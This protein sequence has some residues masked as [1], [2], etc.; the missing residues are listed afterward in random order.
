MLKFLFAFIFGFS[1]IQVNAQS[2][3]LTGSVIDP[4]S[5]TWSYGTITAIF[6]PSPGVPGPYT[7][8]GGA[9]N[10]LPATVSLD[11]GGNFTLS[12]PSNTAIVPSGSTWLINV[13]P[14]AS[15]QC[16]VVNAPLTGGSVNISSLVT[17]SSA[18]P[19]GGISPTQISKVYNVAQAGTPPLNQGGMVYNTT[20][21]TMNVY[22][23]GG[24]TPFAVVGGLP[25]VTNPGGNQ[26]VTQPLNTIFNFITSG[27]G[28]LQHNGNAVLDTTTGLLT[29]TAE[30]YNPS[31]TQTITQP[32]GTSTNLNTFNTIYYSNNY[33]SLALA[34]AAACNGT[35]P[36][37]VI[38]PSGTF[39]QS[40][41]TTIP[42]FCT[43]SGQG[44][45][46]I[47][48]G[49]LAVTGNYVLLKDF[50]V[51]EGRVVTVD[52]IDIAGSHVIMNDMTVDNCGNNGILIANSHVNVQNSDIYN[53]GKTIAG[54]QGTA[55]IQISAATA[56]RD[57]VIINNTIHDNS[58]GIQ[59]ANTGVT[60]QDHSGI[61]FT[62]NR[63]YN[64]AND[65]ILATI[66]N[67]GGGNMTGIRAEN[68][69]IFCNGWP[70]SGAGFST[71]C[72]AGFLQSGAVSS[73][74]G[75]G[76]DIIQQNGLTIL[77]SII[78][79]NY[80]HDN[81]FEAVALSTVINPVVSTSGTAVTWV[82]GTHFNTQWVAGQYILIAGVSYQIASVSSN[83]AL[84]LSTSAGTQTNVGTSVPG[85]MG[86][87]VAN[88]Y[89]LQNGGPCGGGGCTSVGPGFYN[90]LSDGNTY[91]N[92][93]AENAWLDGYI[94]FYS[95][96]TLYTGDSAFSN[97]VGAVSGNQAGFNNSGGF[98]VFYDGVSVGA[99]ST[100]SAV[101]IFNA[102][103]QKTKILANSI[104]ATTPITDT[105]TGTLY[106]ST[107]AT[108]TY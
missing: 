41:F 6:Q 31:S 14:N 58:G 56:I 22:G 71:N 69:E 60:G 21:Q 52:C 59:I 23:T 10:Q 27:T 86:A 90:E 35:V 61:S 89:S 12:L 36:G 5:Y 45:Q 50:A 108:P 25:V 1:V 98:E 32:T 40:G 81:T 99:H 19:V 37:T 11:S 94:D 53:N 4:T 75:V 49:G 101:G 20:N 63:I 48:G 55:G 51:T 85:Y 107:T 103:S 87:I 70:A 104:H 84:T 105:G 79:G 93:I 102:T 24:W 34:V 13:C 73:G 39:A 74:N 3:T 91:A 67:T 7:W 43:L 78:T 65:A 68:N 82:S 16:A 47:I 83:T 64:N 106:L 33:T 100:T 42:S 26:T 2:T 46:S 97:G 80:I 9:F 18:W 28:T 66:S 96:F 62:E 95:S 92:N 15:L 76:V 17:A 29:G 88:N 30:L 77:R 57:I 72:S 54:G 38:I 44:T 8:S